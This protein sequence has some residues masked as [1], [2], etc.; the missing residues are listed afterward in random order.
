MFGFVTRAAMYVVTRPALYTF[1]AGAVLGSGVLSGPEQQDN[2]HQEHQEQQ[3]IYEHPC[4]NLEKGV[5]AP[6]RDDSKLV[7]L[8]KD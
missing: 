5:D 2:V 3:V 4:Y 1:I 7:E 6:K 8:L